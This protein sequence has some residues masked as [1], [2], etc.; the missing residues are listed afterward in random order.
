MEFLNCS[1]NKT[2]AQK[3]N[4][5]L[6]ICN[7]NPSPVKLNAMARIV[8]TTETNRKSF[9]LKAGLSIFLFLQIQLPDAANISESKP[10]GFAAKLHAE[11]AD[12]S[13]KVEKDTSTQIAFAAPVT[14]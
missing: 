11:S 13:C 14:K 12:K 6:A 8:K 10:A 4:V 7:K 3:S 2:E 1:F 9:L 5:I